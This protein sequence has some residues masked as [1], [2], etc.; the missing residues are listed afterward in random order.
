MSISD[1]DANRQAVLRYLSSGNFGLDFFRRRAEGGRQDL[2]LAESYKV[3]MHGRDGMPPSW[4]MQ[5]TPGM[6][7]RQTG[8]GFQFML[9]ADLLKLAPGLRKYW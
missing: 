3:L 5:E 8:P 7:D 1:N 9:N 2:Q 6:P 4:L